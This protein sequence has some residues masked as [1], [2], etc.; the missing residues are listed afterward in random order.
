MLYILDTESRRVVDSLT[1]GGHP[2]RI[3]ADDQGYLYTL[4]GSVTRIH[5]ASKSITPDFISGFFYGMLVD[6]E[7]GRIY[8]TNPVDYVQQGTVEYYSLSGSKLG[9][10]DAGIV[11][12]S[13]ALQ[14]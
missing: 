5:L 8:L 14:P 9:T 10:F 7:D 4:D 3:A 2:T 6:D 11:P 13:M 12:G 1:L